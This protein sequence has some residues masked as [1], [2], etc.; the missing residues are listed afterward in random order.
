MVE[1]VLVLDIVSVSCITS[2]KVA[3]S[4]LHL[5]Y[6]FKT[7]GLYSLVKGKRRV[8]FVLTTWLHDYF[9]PYKLIHI[10]LRY[11]VCHF[12]DVGVYCP[13]TKMTSQLL[14]HPPLFSLKPSPSEDSL[15]SKFLRLKSHGYQKNILAS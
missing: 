13:N 6:I 5:V 3:I 14:S 8:G 15:S 12:F 4:D 10:V 7:S 11:Q 9:W 2:C 1:A